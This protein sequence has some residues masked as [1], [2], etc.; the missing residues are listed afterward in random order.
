MAFPSLSLADQA[1]A[2]SRPPE[3]S[4]LEYFRDVFGHS[5]SIT[6]ADLE[7]VLAAKASALGVELPVP[8]CSITEDPNT[9]AGESADTLVSHHGRTASTS[10][11]GTTNTCLTSQ[12]SHNSTV[13]PAALTE[14]ANVLARKRSKSLTFSQYEKYLS[15][16]D[17]TLSQPKFLGSFA[18]SERPFNTM[19]AS[20]RGVVKDLKR[21]ITSKLRRR[22]HA[23]ALTT[24][25]CICCREEFTK[26]H[27]AL[28]TLPCGHTYCQTCLA[29]MIA[30]ST[31]DES[32]MPPRCCT[33]PIPTTIIKTVLTRDEQHTFLKS[34]LQYSTP[35]ESRIF[36]PNMSCG[37]FVPPRSKIDPKHPFETT[38]KNCK[39]R[40]CIM[41]KRNAHRLG[42]DCPEDF[43]LDAVLK[44]GEKS[45]WRRCYKC[46]T[47]VELTQGC[48]HMT[49]RCKA[50]F[51]YI[52]G[53]VWDPAVGCPNF[54]N[55]EEELERRR[56]EEEARL[57]ELEAEKQAQEEK[58]AAEDLARQEAET[59]TKD[60]AAFMALKEEQEAELARFLGFE[61]KM[62]AAM[63]TRQSQKRLALVER[64]SELMDRMK[65]RHAKTEQHLE[66]R[67]IEAEIEL[68]AALEQS[69]R[70]VRIQLKYM[71]AYCNSLT[72]GS[73]GDMPS[74]KVTEKHL[75]QLSQQYR[76]RDGMEQ[77]HQSQIN[78]L[79]EKQGKR[80]EE[81]ME[82]HEKEMEI[83]MDKNAEEIEDLAVEFTNDEEALARVFEERKTKLQRRWELAI[84]ILRV[85]MESLH[86]TK[87]ATL[88]PPVWPAEPSE[89]DAL[90]VVAEEVGQ[91]H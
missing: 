27:D 18:R 43:G 23:P 67:Q 42:Q 71:E 80:M 37:E 57:A 41:C 73:N 55:G 4:D 20:R 24:V 74:R 10:S 16:L 29:V 91:A 33:Q 86:K 47:L 77:R 49:C 52:C 25:S 3:L 69:E 53:A 56:M 90:A 45:G 87:F 84:E 60:N 15:Q 7:Q 32:K 89:T 58:A 21:S 35:W 70:S 48:T 34:V 82:R 68:Q 9:S 83:L 40:I 61:R 75:E 36:C 17:P 39:T 14:S 19:M 2:P 54:C 11:N 64:H 31:L 38:C 76:I 59:R 62:I 78:V 63:R 6:E 65:E 28:Q 8:R 30:Q 88:A 44:M 85:E 79:R 13:I 50:Q 46:R 26:D 22:R 81:L 12:T 72:K 1:D 66:D 51:C 5:S